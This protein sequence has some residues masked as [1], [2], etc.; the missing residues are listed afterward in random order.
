MNIEKQLIEG[1]QAAFQHHYQHVLASDEI[2]LQPTRKD[3]AG[4]HTFVTFPYARVTRQS[5]PQTAET[6]G[7]Y[8]KEQVGIVKDFNVVKGFL[9]IE[10]ADS[11]WVSTLQ[12][13]LQQYQ[14]EQPYGF[15]PDNGKKV[16]VEFSSPNT[17]K[18]LHLGHLRNNFLGDAMSRILRAN[19]YAVHNVNIVN[20][21]G[22]HICKSMLAYQKFGQGETPESAGLKGDHLVGKY[23]VEFDK[24]YKAEISQLVAQGTEEEQAKKEAPLMKEA[25]EMLKQ[26]EQGEA[27]TVALWKKMNAWVYEGFDATYQKIG[28]SFDQI[29]Y[30]S[31][32]YLLGKDIVEEGLEKEVFYRKEDG[33]VWIDLSDEGLD[34]KLVL[35]GDGTSVYM[36]QDLGTAE[37]RYRDWPFNRLVY[38]VGNEQNYHFKVLFSILK[39]LG[40]P[41][42]DGLFHLSY[43]MVDLPSG[44]MKSREGTVVDADDLIDEVIQQ[45]R[46]KTEA[47]GKIE[48][49]TPS[50]AEELFQMLGLGAIKY[51]LLKVDPKKR[52]LFNPEESV[53]LQGD[54]APFIQ[55]THARISAILQKATHDGINHEAFGSLSEIHGSEQEVI[56]L[57]AVFPQKVQLAGAEYAPSVIA[58]YVFDLAKAYNRFYSEVSI[59]AEKDAD[60]VA[61]R[62]AL[63]SAVAQTISAGLGLLGIQAP[64]QM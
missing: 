20:D 12:S 22:I 28:V 21:R 11:V 56:E 18:P 13:I 51:F 34:E 64:K 43:G 17:N 31:D 39:R 58:Q 48:E 3:F 1:I 40:R 35:R 38:V 52:M 60:K 62:V 54:T 46:K 41:Y 2:G 30:E 14:S 10:L 61:F 50:Q 23:Y 9:N 45:A 44:K 55:Y 19:G 49:L 16:M 32:T 47:L 42:A 7:N 57:L 24:H 63:S 27:E 6:I 8:L 4:S 5:P 37:L 25:Q 53:Q 29:Y 26:W 15:Q 33:S 59:F 36:T